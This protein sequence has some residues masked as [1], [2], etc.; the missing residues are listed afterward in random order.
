[1]SE[2]LFI[3]KDT[4]DIVDLD[5]L[6]HWFIDAGY[7]KDSDAYVDKTHHSYAEILFEEFNN[8][9]DHNLGYEFEVIESNM[10]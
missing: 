5:G 6:F 2:Y 3:I 9:Y 7:W 1:M 4:R 8:W 10:S